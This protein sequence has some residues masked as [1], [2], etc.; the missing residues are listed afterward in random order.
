MRAARTGSGSVYARHVVFEPTALDGVMVVD[1]QPIADERGFF[2]RAFCA[3]EFAAHGL[4]S[5]FVQANMSGNVA[6]STT[7]GLHYQDERAPE[8]K[9]FRCIRGETFHVAVDARAESPTFGRWVGVRLS[10]DLRRAL[11]I[12]PLHAAGYQALTD[13]AEVHYLCSAPYTP[14]AEAGLN[15]RDPTI[16]I[17]WPLQPGVVSAKDQA[18][19]Y[20]A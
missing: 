3:E 9:F 14:E 10:A 1:L 5:S 8:A 18:W 20:L 12:P 2:A 13:G 17:E 4:V 15:I 16:G 11:Y 7:R 19:A 6:A